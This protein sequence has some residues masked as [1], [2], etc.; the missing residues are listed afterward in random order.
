[1]THLLRYTGDVPVT[2]MEAGHVE[3]GAEFTVP[4]ERLPG[5]MRRADV[6]HAAECPRPP[7]RCG[8][9]REPSDG[10]GGEEPP[11][12]PGGDGTGPG[13]PDPGSAEAEDVTRRGGRKRAAEA[14]PGGAEAAA[15]D[16]G[17][18]G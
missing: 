13:A 11:G 9:E 2:F 10:E 14:R 12:L 3:P 18:G 15:G 1:V 4:G 6:E 7:C 16:A 8:E 5:F 17:E